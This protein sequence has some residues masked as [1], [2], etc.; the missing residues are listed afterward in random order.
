MYSIL[1]TIFA[2]DIDETRLKLLAERSSGEYSENIRQD[3]S[4]IKSK[5]DENLKKQ[6][7]LS[8]IFTE[9]LLAKESYKE[10]IIPLR[11]DERDLKR[12]IKRLE[13]T[14][15]EKESSK[16]YKNILKS[17]IQHVDS[18]KTGLDI[19]GKKGLLRLVFKSISVENGKIKNFG[20]YEPF[21]SLY[22]GVQIQCKNEIN[23]AVLTI[24]ESVSTCVPSDA[25]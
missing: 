18:I 6:S 8:E 4:E 23:Q 24:P 12:K 9:G 20:L 21:K 22:E 16:E 25:R 15:I 1:E 11:D 3:I 5:L 17:V 7:R 19:T 10:Q 2:G 13:L 14:L